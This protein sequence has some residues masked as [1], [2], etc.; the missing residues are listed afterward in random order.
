M[1]PDDRPPDVSGE[2]PADRRGVEAETADQAAGGAVSE[3]GTQIFPPGSRRGGRFVEGDVI[4]NRYRIVGALGEGG[5][6]QVWHAFDLKLR[7]DVALK[8]LRRE[9]IGDEGRV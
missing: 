2:V 9:L 3:G 6:G 4:A 7:V 8:S 5:M 1:A